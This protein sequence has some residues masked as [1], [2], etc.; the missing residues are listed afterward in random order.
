M[1]VVFLTSL[2]LAVVMTAAQARVGEA[3]PELVSRYG[4]PLPKSDEKPPPNMVGSLEVFQKNGFQIDVTLLDGVSA[5][6]SF[7]KLNG[8]SFSS[9]EIETLLADNAQGRAWQAPH[10]V[11]GQTQWMCDNGSVAAL[12]GHTLQITSA[13]LL[14]T[15]AQAKQLD[16]APSLDGF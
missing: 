7:K 2:F 8:D 1:K 3:L 14:D 13:T 6:E 11:N 10:K 5:Q 12:I 15:K 9:E 4:D 16:H